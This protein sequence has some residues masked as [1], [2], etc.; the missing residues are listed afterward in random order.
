M[1]QRSSNTEPTQIVIA[2]TDAIKI[3]GGIVI[4]LIG[5]LTWIV[6]ATYETKGDVRVMQVQQATNRE[7]LKSIGSTVQA[8]K[9]ILETKANEDENTKAHDALSLKL[10][11]LE[12]GLREISAGRKYTSSNYDTTNRHG[13]S[14]NKATIKPVPLASDN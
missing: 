13:G 10:D 6:V 11:G 2:N 3:V 5:L 12:I 4:L 14:Y 7:F 8:N 1:S 9:E